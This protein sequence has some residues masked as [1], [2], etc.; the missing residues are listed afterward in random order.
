MSE[1]AARVVGPNTDACPILPGAA[2]RSPS[3]PEW[4]THARVPESWDA[5]SRAA[6]GHTSRPTTT[7][8]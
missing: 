1:A 5:V 2:M 8:R 6:L 3:F 7:R 4:L